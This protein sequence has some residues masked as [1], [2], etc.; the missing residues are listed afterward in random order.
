MKYKVVGW[1]HPDDYSILSPE[2]PIGYAEIYAIVDDIKENGYLFSGWHHQESYNNV[3]PV[4]NDGMKR[5]F[6]QRSWGGIMAM[7]NNE[8][9]DYAYSRYTFYESLKKES[10]V[11]PEKSYS[12]KDKSVVENEHF[13][14]SISEGLFNI[15]KNNNY[16][17]LEDDERLRYI[18]INDTITLICNDEKVTYKVKTVDRNKNDVDFKESNLIK[19]EFKIILSY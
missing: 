2:K 17:Y 19:G 15:A 7:A 12:K 13:E 6:S 10:L 9:G 16:C 1:T 8:I 4:L 5:E 18:D 11:F 14:I 3:V